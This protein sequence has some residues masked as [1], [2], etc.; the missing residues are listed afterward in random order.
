MQIVSWDV[1]ITEGNDCY[2]NFVNNLVYI[3]FQQIFP[4]VRLSR[5]R[6][7]RVSLSPVTLRKY[8]N[9]CL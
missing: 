1:Y 2:D 9:I 8:Q 4:S 6:A 3:K 7:K 5:K